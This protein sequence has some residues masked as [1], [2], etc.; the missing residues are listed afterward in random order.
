MLRSTR[1]HGL[2]M[3]VSLGF[4]IVLGFTLHYPWWFPAL[5]DVW[6]ALG[7]VV[8]W[9]RDLLTYQEFFIAGV[10]VALHFDGGMRV[11]L[12]TLPSDLPT[13][14]SRRRF[15]GDLVCHPGRHGTTLL[16]ASDPYQP[17]AVI[18]YFA[19]IAAIF[20]LS[21]WWEQRKQGIS[22]VPRRGATTSAGLAAL[23][24][25][26]WLSHN[27]FL[28]SLRAVLGGL[29][30][31]A[32]LPWEATVAILF[33]GTVLLSVALVAVILR[34][35][36][37]WILGGPVRSERRAEYEADPDTAVAMQQK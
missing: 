17:E 14:W 33:F 15:D 23:I 29:G 24:G 37:K 6:N 13:Q 28:T 11:R 26:V 34:T 7:S 9:S 18:W 4:A 3:A 25:G 2:I 27:L 1:R 21:Q 32:S 22:G 10:L 16:R 20:A 30:L 5:T 35:P 36:L 8:P 19:A 12:W 31:R